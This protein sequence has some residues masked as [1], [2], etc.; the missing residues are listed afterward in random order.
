[1]VKELNF[2]VGGEA[3][4]GV[5][6]IGFVLAKAMTRFGF[7]VFADQDYESRIRGGHN[8]FRIRMSLDPVQAFTEKVDILIALNQETIDL[9]R[10]EVREGGAAIFD[11]SRIKLEGNR[12]NSLKIPLERLA[13]DTTSNKLMTNSVAI[14]AAIA[15]AGYDFDTLARILTEHFAGKGLAE[16]NVTA[17]RAGYDHA[18][19]QPGN[20]LEPPPPP[21]LADKRM[22]LNGNEALALGAMAAG[23]KFVAAYP[24]TPTSSIMEYITEKGRKYD[25]ITVQPEDEIAAINMVIGA[26]FAGVRAMTVTSGSG[27][28]LMVE[29]LGLAGITETPLV[30]V[31][32]QR[33]GPA[34]G[35]PTRTEQGELAFALHAGTGEF[36][37]ALLA[38]V[39]IEDNFATAVTAFNLAERY[40]T[41]V[42]ILTDHHLAT[43]YQDVK[44]FDLSTV[45]IDRGELLT[46]EELGRISDYKRHRYTDSGISPRA[47][48]GQ[49]RALVVTDSDEHDEAGHLVEDA[50]T[51][52]KMVLKRMKKLQGLKGEPAPPRLEETPGAQVTFI[53]WGSSYGAIKEAVTLLKGEGVKCNMAHLNQVYPFPAKEVAMALG[54]TGR[55]LAVEMNAT[56]QLARL[57]RTETGIEVSGSILKFDGRPFSAAHIMSELKKEVAYAP[58][59][60]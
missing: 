49:G 21:G 7:H 18:R 17:A 53:G 42:I 30:A 11:E 48:P 50:E 2:M 26:A 23:C 12:I 55:S 43:S 27:F 47:Y 58:W 24:M 40:Q 34:V 14:G 20:G 1:M 51:R 25:I 6:T 45:K 4:Q 56:A 16:P 10:N 39:D 29:G 46:D 57:I 41:P 54:K 19:R 5:Q 13:V 32:G 44:A 37:R 36:P 3:G 9:H 15:A 38:P 59:Q 8:F 22:L 28:A 52:S 60:R 31:L 33:P 35:L